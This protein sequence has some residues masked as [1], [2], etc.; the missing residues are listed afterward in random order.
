M[1]AWPCALEQRIAVAGVCGGSFFSSLDI[2]NRARATGRGH[3][4]DT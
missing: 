2:K 1:V 3:R 4:Q